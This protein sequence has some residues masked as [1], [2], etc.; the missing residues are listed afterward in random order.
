MRTPDSRYTSAEIRRTHATPRRPAVTTPLIAS[1]AVGAGQNTGNFSIT[2]P[3]ASGDQQFG[4][5]TPVFACCGMSVASRGML[6]QQITIGHV[7]AGSSSAVTVIVQVAP[8]R[9]ISG[10]YACACAIVAAS[11]LRAMAGGRSGDGFNDHCP[12]ALLTQVADAV[13]GIAL[14]AVVMHGHLARKTRG[15][16]FLSSLIFT[17]FHGV[18]HISE[19]IRR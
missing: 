7:A 9:S 10:R 3:Q 11:H 14:R 13:S 6:K 1:T 4:L 19:G 8:V 18:P 2:V 5:A 16:Q 17:D 15:P 12:S